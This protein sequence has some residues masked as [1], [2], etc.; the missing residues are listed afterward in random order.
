MAQIELC[1]VHARATSKWAEVQ[2]DRHSL[3]PTLAL[4]VVL[5]SSSRPFYFDASSSFTPTLHNSLP[6]TYTQQHSFPSSDD[7]GLALFSLCFLAM[8]IDRRLSLPSLGSVSKDVSCLVA[9]SFDAS[10]TMSSLDLMFVRGRPKRRRRKKPS[11]H[12]YVRINA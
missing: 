12:R 5:R 10:Q 1:A 6:S 9:V 7:E 4:M 11:I 3:L 8:L 2:T